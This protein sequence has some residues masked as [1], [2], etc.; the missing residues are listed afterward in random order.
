MNICLRYVGR[1]NIFKWFIRWDTIFHPNSISTNTPCFFVCVCFIVSVSVS[2]YGK[3]ISL[4][5]PLYLPLPQSYLAEE[6]KVACYIYGNGY[7]LGYWTTALCHLPLPCSGKRERKG[8]R[9]RERQGGRENERY[10]PCETLPSPNPLL[11][12]SSHILPHA[13]LPSPL[14][15]LRYPISDLR[16]PYFHIPLHITS[17]PHEP[18]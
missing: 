7:G 18:H 6:G 11:L 10:S 8:E 13:S 3:P 4:H 5:L 1:N 16:S 2:S 17:L 9:E 12:S 14:A 15:T